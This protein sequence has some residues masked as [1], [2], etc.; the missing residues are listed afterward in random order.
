MIM[1]IKHLALFIFISLINLSTVYT[2]VVSITGQVL[3]HNGDPLP[4][5]MVTCSNGDFIITDENGSFEFSD[6]LSGQDYQ[7]DGFYEATIFEE[8]SVL[9]ACYNRFIV[10]QIH[11]YLNSQ[12][13]ANDYNQD[14]IYQGLDF[15]RIAN[16]SIK[17]ENSLTE[18]DAPWRF[19]DGYIDSININTN[20]I[21]SGI[22]LENLSSDTSGL[23]LIAV[24]SGDVAI[25]VDH[26]PP[27]SYAPHPTLYIPDMTIEQNEEIL[28]SL[29]VRDLEKIM[30]FQH[31]LVW[32]TTY[33]EFIAYENKTDI[34]E[35]IPNEAHVDEGLFPIMGIDVNAL[36]G[37]QT[38]ADDSTIYELRFKALQDA[39][40]LI[41]ILEFDHLFIQKQVV[42]LD[43]SDFTLYLIEAEC[44]IEE[45]EP[46]AVNL[47]LNHLVSFDISPN[48]VVE[49]LRFSIQFLKA[50]P[51]ILSLFDTNGKLLQKQTF[52]SQTITGEMQI[53]NLQKG[54]Y[55]LQ[56]QTKE[57]LSSRSFIKL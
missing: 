8:I 43:S 37:A 35:L 51:S 11:N 46:T 34:F 27:P 4:D 1:I 54:N 26:E 9:D 10:N 42:Y 21:E 25:D 5:V 3:R 52:D 39:N 13:I 49:E 33:L 12:L 48:P 7:I 16:A 30:G 38:I 28:V 57:G 53:K 24:K 40:S 41:G 56:V 20:D 15:I 29:K 23:V 6:L 2:Q 18:L 36:S 45:N 17:I 50:E 19:F 31:G 14:G 55:Y 22:N 44:I 32:D 47:N